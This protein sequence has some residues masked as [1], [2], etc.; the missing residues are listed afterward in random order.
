MIPAIQ[1]ALYGMAYHRRMLNDAAENISRVSAN[2]RE[3]AGPPVD[4]AHEMV[5]MLVAKHGFTANTKTFKVADEMI[6]SLLDVFA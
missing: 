2:Y 4:L 6:G 5:N 3:G 1:H